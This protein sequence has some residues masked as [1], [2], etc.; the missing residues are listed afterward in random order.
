M[1]QIDPTPLGSHLDLGGVD[2]HITGSRE[3]AAKY[4]NSFCIFTDGSGFK[5]RISTA[6]VPKVKMEIG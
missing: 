3:E 6:A 2:F 1:E 4:N 5:G